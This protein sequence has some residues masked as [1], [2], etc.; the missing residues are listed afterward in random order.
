[1][2][3]GHSYVLIGENARCFGWTDKLNVAIG[4]ARLLAAEEQVRVVIGLLK[5]DVTWH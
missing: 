4:A 2:L 5:G 3:E 1:M